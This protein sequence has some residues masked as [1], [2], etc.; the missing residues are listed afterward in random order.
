MWGAIFDI[1]VLVAFIAQPHVGRLCMRLPEGSAA[2][3]EDRRLPIAG[4]RRCFR[5]SGGPAGHRLFS[6]ADLIAGVE[7][8]TNAGC[9]APPERQSSIHFVSTTFGMLQQSLSI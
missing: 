2:H 5:A 6:G 9:N 8:R 7:G 4:T 1:N 3:L